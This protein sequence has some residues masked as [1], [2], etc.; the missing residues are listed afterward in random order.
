MVKNT[1][2]GNRERARRFRQRRAERGLTEIMVIAPPAARL[3]LKIASDLMSRDVDPLP[4]AD[5]LLAAAGAHQA[6][7]S[8]D[9]ER[10]KEL[11]GALE[12][13]KATLEKLRAQ[14]AAEVAKSAAAEAKA[15]TT[16]ADAE[17][18][19]AVARRYKNQA[20]KA[21]EQVAA[22]EAKAKALHEAGGLKG[23]AI[24]VLSGT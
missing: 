22:A 20:E 16:A 17:C 7:A 13:Q 3:L 6:Q 1:A 21:K 8:T 4:P 2:E 18:Y 14:L 5:A 11:Q 12:A 24:R 19:A 23:L 15:A 10:I 9:V